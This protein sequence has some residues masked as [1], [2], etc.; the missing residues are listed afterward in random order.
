MESLM[1]LK[2]LIQKIADL[3]VK[4]SKDIEITGLCANSKVVAPGNL[5]I[6]KKGLAHD[7]TR[8]IPDAVAAGAVAI[9]TDMYD[10]FLQVTQLI[11]PDVASIEA[12]LA[13]EYY[14]NPSSELKIIGIT[15]TNGKTTSSFLIKHLLDKA[16]LLAGLIGTIEWIVGDHRFPTSMTT[17]DTITNHKLLREMASAGCK[18]CVMEVS[19]HGLDQKRV[20][21]IDFDIAVFTNF[22]QD[23]L[24]YHKDME[25]YKNAKAKLFS[26]LRE[27]KWAIFNAD[28]PVQFVTKAKTLTYAIDNQADL[29]AKELKLSDKGIQFIASYQGQ[30]V[31]C[32]SPLVGRFNIYNLLATIAVGLCSKVALEECIAFIKSFKGVL[33]RL[34]R[35]KNGRGL[36]IF[37]DY[38]HTEDA[39]SRVLETINGI[40]KGNLL[41]VFG[42]GGDRDQDKREKMGRVASRLSDE[43]IITS[44]NPRNEDP[45]AIVKQ[46]LQG[47]PEKFPVT[48][49]LDRECAIRRAI[50]KMGK[51]DILLIAGKGHEKKQIFANRV[52]P[53][54]DVEIA[55]ALVKEKGETC[56]CC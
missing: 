52:I 8:F 13:A 37:V 2:R 35:V 47:V 24:D 7:G 46:I 25:S 30:E 56:D 16:G 1:R 32:K 6:A 17:L 49:E 51:D 54:D 31:L 11:H 12:K 26:R 5:F 39:L 23:H 19:S 41:T 53:F 29:M 15:G 18:S 20:E 4:G 50:Q 36:H 55:Q 38:A 45:E 21:E 22:S 14:H 27:D 48:V 43:V 9:L 28:D 3:E 42:C 34:E 40:K 33:G 44:D 10:P